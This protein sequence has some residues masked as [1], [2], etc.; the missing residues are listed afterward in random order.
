MALQGGNEVSA[1]QRNAFVQELQER[2][3]V[4]H[5]AVDP[6]SGKFT[7]Q[8]QGL[9]GLLCIFGTGVQAVTVPAC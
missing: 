2:A 1:R 5:A 4:A 6:V 9:Q 7:W 3:P 8:P